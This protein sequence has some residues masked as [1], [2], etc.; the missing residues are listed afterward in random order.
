[1]AISKTYQ[2][3]DNGTKQS[4]RMPK[5]LSGDYMKL[6]ERS[7]DDLLAQLA[8]YAKR[9]VYYD[10]NMN[11]SGDWREF[12]EDVYDYD[13]HELK[14]EH[15]KALS[16]AGD[17]PPHLALMMAFL[18][19]YEVEQDNINTLTDRHLQFYYK[20]I[21]GFKQQEGEN[22]KATVFFEP[23]KNASETFIP[24]GTPFDAGKDANGKAITYRSVRDVTVN[25]IKV[26]DFFKGI[27]K[28]DASE[29]ATQDSP[30]TNKQPAL[31]TTSIPADNA[32][33]QQNNGFA[34][35]SPIL[36]L[37]D[38]QRT[39]T[40]KGCKKLPEKLIIEFTGEKG[41]EKARCTDNKI[42][43]DKNQGAIVP[44]D[45]KTHGKGYDSPYP[46]LRIIFT[47]DVHIVNFNGIA[48]SVE[49]SRDFALKNNYGAFPNTPGTM[50]WGPQPVM[51][52]CFTLT[53]NSKINIDT[54]HI[55]WLDDKSG[56]K[57]IFEKKSELK[58]DTSTKGCSLTTNDK[59]YSIK[60]IREL[61]WANYT[62]AFIENTQ[63]MFINNWIKNLHTHKS[64]LPETITLPRQPY[65][66]ILAEPITIDYT[67][68]GSSPDYNTDDIPA[69]SL[70]IIT[71][72]GI[73]DGLNGSTLIEKLT[74]M[75]SRQE[76]SSLSIKLSGVQ[77]FGIL[78]L[79][80]EMNP[81]KYKPDGNYGKETP[82][83]YYNSCEGWTAFGETD[84]ISDTTERFSR[85]GIVQLN[86][87]DA[88]VSAAGNPKGELWLRIDA[89]T[90]DS[91]SPSISN[92]PFDALEAVL[93][94]AVE[95][96]LDPR[97]EGQIVIG[98]ALPKGSITKAKSSIKGIKKIDQPY[99][100]LEGRKDETNAKFYA[101]VSER[102]RHKGRAWNEWDY[103]RLVL[104]RFPK[105]ASVKCLP[106]HCCNEKGETRMEP[107]HVTLVVVPDLQA[108]PQPNKLRPTIGKAMKD[109]IADYVR[110]KAPSFI[111]LHVIS[112]TYKEAKVH[113][114]II[115]RKGLTD[116]NHYKS[117][118][119]DKLIEC[120]APWVSSE[121]HEI[122]FEN[123][124]NESQ[125][126]AFIENLECVDHFEG[127]RL[128]IDDKY[129]DYGEALRPDDVTSIITTANQ[130]EI[131]V[132]TFE[133]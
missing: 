110:Q 7:F 39:I 51:G 88:V 78:T 101:R 53:T 13:K 114:E 28:T 5:A 65:M 128:S 60:L 98:T 85:S 48:V 105:V 52:S 126:Q 6:D 19:M 46:I 91:A 81:F 59:G 120:F 14:K 106:C 117:L 77:T 15:I 63:K 57:D 35:S 36:N 115:L 31:T 112:P 87:S 129:I 11:P 75:K 90:T 102:L 116:T 89:N 109:E 103:E 12:F 73:Q 56:D 132:Q 125:I 27:Q 108:V 76:R 17:V 86:I 20:D 95:V 23:V 119:N 67:I 4:D 22:G 38:G 1:M 107:G 54:I 26:V 32:K 130:H 30:F 121:A 97:S 94:Q 21:L 71:P 100:G 45:I 99:N 47:T 25:Q 62:K 111:E 93:A 127:F 3:S 113:C 55:H 37:P 123:N 69:P 2:W 44:Y 41:W 16:E 74:H 131:N 82:I 8:E 72:Y 49:G 83:W 10:D 118:I 70:S 24:K 64:P 61:G 133:K 18:K 66:P 40:L 80:F 34:I 104:E 58:Q 9:L 96:E 42:T 43:V 92:N 79:H 68:N 33:T 122:E 84:L 124:Q 29:I 50:P